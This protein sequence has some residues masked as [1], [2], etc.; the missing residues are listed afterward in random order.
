MRRKRM[1]LTNESVGMHAVDSGLMIK[2]QTPELE[3]KGTVLNAPAFQKP[4]I[5]EN[6]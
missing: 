1:G 4:I 3:Q 5:L 6:L 2:K